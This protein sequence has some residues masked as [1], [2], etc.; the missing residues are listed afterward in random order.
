MKRLCLHHSTAPIITGATSRLTVLNIKVCSDAII[1]NVYVSQVSVAAS[2]GSKPIG[3]DH[4]SAGTRIPTVF[5]T[6]ND[7]LLARRPGRSFTGLSTFSTWLDEHLQEHHRAEWVDDALPERRLVPAIS[8]AYGVRQHSL[9][10]PPF[11]PR[12]HF[13]KISPQGFAERVLHSQK[14]ARSRGS[15][16]AAGQPC[17]PQGIRPWSRR[18]L[19]RRATRQR[20]AA[21]HPAAN[22]KRSRSSFGNE[23]QSH[24]FRRL[25]NRLSPSVA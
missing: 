11:R 6:S 3:A 15:Q 17:R 24:A 8:L 16:D 21:A 10:F 13:A 14:P 5:S 25:P 1:H 22:G 18:Q 9:L 7:V 12:A 23:R 2:V 19:P 20:P 4:T